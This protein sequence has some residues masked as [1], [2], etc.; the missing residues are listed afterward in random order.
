M[1]S[2]SIIYAQYQVCSDALFKALLTGSH[3]QKTVAVK[4]KIEILRSRIAMLE[5]LFEEPASDGKETERREGLLTYASG[6]YSDWILKP[7]Q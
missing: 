5:K 3:L 6:F 1:E 2:I 7:C 4:D